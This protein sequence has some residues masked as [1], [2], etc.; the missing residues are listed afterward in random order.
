MDFPPTGVSENLD[1]HSMLSGRLA[2]FAIIASLTGLLTGCPA[3]SHLKNMVE[4][5]WLG[6]RPGVCFPPNDAW[7]SN[8]NAMVYFYRP[9]SQWAAD[10]IDAP[11]VYIDDRHYFNIRGNGYT[12]LEMAP[13]PS[14]GSPCV[15]L[16]GCA[17]IRGNQAFCAGFDCG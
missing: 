1:A 6:K 8:Q 14:A 16:G 2:Q 7:G 3:V 15:A 17:G 9:N 4:H 12:W 13:R 11:S 10:E 5:F